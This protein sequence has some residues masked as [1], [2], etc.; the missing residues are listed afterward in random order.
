MLQPWKLTASARQAKLVRVLA[1]LPVGYRRSAEVRSE[2]RL[3]SRAQIAKVEQLAK[4]KNE[5]W[6][7][8]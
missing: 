1:G 5:S 8:K 6:S 4:A 3:L 2:T 7:L